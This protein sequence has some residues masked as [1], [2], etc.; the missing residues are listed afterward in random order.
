M[1]LL[2]CP[3]PVF[4]PAAALRDAHSAKSAG[5][6][7]IEFRLDDF[8][9]GDELQIA[10][11][12]H[13]ISESPLPCIATCR[14]VSEGGSYDGPDDARIALFERLGTA[15]GKGEHPPRYIDIELATYDRS[16]NIR[17]KI[18]LAIDHHEQVRDLQTSLILSTHDFK[19]LPS[20]L[21][22]RVLAMS[23]HPVAKV[24]KIA[25]LARSLRDNLEVFDLL[26]HRDRPMIALTMGEPG[27]MSRVLAPKFGGFLAFA[28]LRPSTTTAPGQPTI[29][30]LL[31]LYRF[32]SINPQTAVYGV[33]G[34]P[35]SHSLSPHIHNAGFESIG[36]NGVYLPMPVSPGYESLKATILELIHHPALALRGLSVTLPHKENIVQLAREQGWGLDESASMM[37]AA[38]TVCIERD[39]SG[40]VANVKVFNTDA[41]AVVQSVFEAVGPLQGKRVA[42]LGAGGVAKAAAHAL[43]EAGASISIFNRTLS[44]AQALARSIPGAVALLPSDLHHHELDILINCTP[45]GMAGGPAP[46]AMPIDPAHIRAPE[47]Y[48]AVMD[49]IYMPIDTPFLRAARE[50]GLR[51]IDGVSMFVNQAAAQFTRWTGAPAP[52]R[53]FERI[54]R[55]HAG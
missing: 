26:T 39:S 14:P 37:N 49:T 22:R 9:H 20:D 30:E 1:T 53:L 2:C 47:P 33:I 41:P 35:V 44:R 38:N 17:Q 46:G 45:L 15:F 3:I 21:S 55:E 24:L 27:L 29:S 31:N 42:I 48:T 8:F 50:A 40:G 36:H 32:R 7:L 11:I 16:A 13:L 43:S 28:S 10:Q 52:T 6:D 51:T 25:F 18:N 5:A 19:G 54:V 4:D 34:S 12:V 23:G